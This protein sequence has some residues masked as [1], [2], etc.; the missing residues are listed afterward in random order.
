MP[1]SICLHYE[2]CQIFLLQ[3]ENRSTTQLGMIPSTLITHKIISF[4][5]KH[6]QSCPTSTVLPLR[7]QRL[8]IGA[9]L[10]LSNKTEIYY[11]KWNI[12]FASLW[13][14]WLVWNDLVLRNGH[15]PLT[16]FCHSNLHLVIEFTYLNTLV[17][18]TLR[19]SKWV[20][21]SLVEDNYIKIKGCVNRHRKVP[22]N[23]SFMSFFSSLLGCG[24]NFIGRKKY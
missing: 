18:L 12:L 21:W 10:N 8:P 6:L 13:I 20:L 3:Q 24:A 9:T 2:S 14:I 16:S 15:H 17:N 11:T 19:A 23:S 1:H 22:L 4:T 7:H 5:M